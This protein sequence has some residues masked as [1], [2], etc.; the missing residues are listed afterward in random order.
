MTRNIGQ[1]DRA[2]RIV[3]GLALISL[4]FVG[5]QT[6]WGWVGVVPLL[7]GLIRWCPPYALL[8]IDTCKKP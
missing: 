5:P 6:P 4:V 1:L 2:I 7:T 3:L 8:G